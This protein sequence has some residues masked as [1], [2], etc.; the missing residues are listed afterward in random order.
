M[1]RRSLLARSIPRRRSRALPSTAHSRFQRSVASRLGSHQ[2]AFLHA[3]FIAV[4]PAPNSSTEP[5][6]TPL[7][8]V[9]AAACTSG[10]AITALSSTCFSFPRSSESFRTRWAV[11]RATLRKWSQAS[12]DCWCVGALDS[13]VVRD[14]SVIAAYA[15]RTAMTARTAPRMIQPCRPLPNGGRRP[16]DH[17]VGAGGDGPAMGA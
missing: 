3:S 12:F 14:D 9:L 13:V 15:A 10:V 2:P 4:A 11:S 5:I 8:M 17:W 1:F 7:N 6:V 16:G